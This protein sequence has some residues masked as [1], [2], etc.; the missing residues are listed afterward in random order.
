MKVVIVDYGLGNLF[1]VQQACSHIG[2]T[3]VISEDKST[4][5]SADVLI[6]PGVGAF[7]KAIE[8]LHERDLFCAIQDFAAANKPILGI[9]LGMQLLLDDSEEFG[10]HKGLGIISGTVKKLPNIGERIPRVG[11][12]GLEETMEQSEKHSSLRLLNGQKE[13]VYFVHSF[14]VDPTCAEDI[15]ATTRWGDRSYC[16]AVSKGKIIGYQFHPEKSGPYGLE[17]LNSFFQSLSK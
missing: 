1:S 7:G 13:D 15:L 3:A 2:I 12:F 6:L 8:N 5:L 17:I 16:S 11:W 14:F 10:N 9:C 4:V